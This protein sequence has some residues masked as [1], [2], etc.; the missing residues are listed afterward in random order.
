MNTPAR[1]LTVAGVVLAAGIAGFL[2]GEIMTR[3]PAGA[4]AVIDNRFP[5][6]AQ[7]DAA[8]LNAFRDALAVSSQSSGF[9]SRQR[10]ILAA[11]D[12]LT[13]EDM[14]AAFGALQSL[15]EGERAAA[16]PAFFG[17]WAELDPVAAI[18]RAPV[19]REGEPPSR[20]I[21]AVYRV[22]V[23]SDPAAAVKWVRAIPK[24]NV[25][26]TDADALAFA[27]ASVAPE[28]GLA[29]LQS[30]LKSEGLSQ[31]VFSV[32]E[33]AV[34]YG[35]FFGT[36]AEADGPRAAASALALPESATRVDAVSAAAR[37]WAGADG[38]AALAWAKQIPE[39]HEREAVT[40]AVMG[41]LCASDPRLAL[42]TVMQLPE[43]PARALKLTDTIRK[44]APQHPEMAIEMVA[45]LPAGRTTNRAVVELSTELAKV[46]AA[47]AALLLDALPVGGWRNEASDEIAKEWAVQDR[48]AALAWAAQ[49]PGR[50][51]FDILVNWSEAD[52]AA[53]VAW[54]A[55][56][57]KTGAFATL[58]AAWAR[59]NHDAAIAW[60]QALP[61]DRTR[62]GVIS[63]LVQGVANSDP[64]RAAKI[65][66]TELHG[67]AQ[68]DAAQIL[69]ND[70]RR[71]DAAAAGR[72]AGTVPS[73]SE[74]IIKHRDDM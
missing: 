2:L 53:A 48:D 10:G 29:S 69:F 21:A 7:H 37:V 18:K 51:L 11:L 3:D 16:L 17:R 58:G 64:A 4:R 32:A 41:A 25:R 74:E 49:L 1:F 40:D 60:A 12:R 44:I 57:G 73:L 72:W 45:L 47:S 67:K 8:A 52:P 35:N 46:D 63:Q 61:K 68:A 50:A 13:N 27:L 22:W 66:T 5:A 14:P 70:W 56:H 42:A 28:A 54:A 31:R 65:I 9:L 23:Q 26:A 38:R 71:N 20:A 62:D 6:R 43:G 36:W 34:L 15:D 19:A 30:L 59:R 39:P 55:A 33:A 24:N